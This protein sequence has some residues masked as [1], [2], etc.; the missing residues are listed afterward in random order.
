[1]SLRRFSVVQVIFKYKGSV[2]A[3]GLVPAILEMF[4]QRLQR[5]R[6]EV[7]RLQDGRNKPGSLNLTLPRS[8]VLEMSLLCH[9]QP[10]LLM[11]HARSG[12]GWR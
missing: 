9:D 4:W 5:R 12:G 10:L 6:L 2:Q 11:Q 3:T 7:K 8:N 1:M